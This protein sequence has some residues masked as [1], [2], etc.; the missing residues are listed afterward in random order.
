MARCEQNPG[1]DA[2]PDEKLSWLAALA[3]AIVPASPSDSSSSMPES[4]PS[5]VAPGAAVKSTAAATG[6]GCASAAEAALFELAALG[7]GSG[8]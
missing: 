7:I 8:S 6:G 4:H 2:S 5:P 1:A 3:A